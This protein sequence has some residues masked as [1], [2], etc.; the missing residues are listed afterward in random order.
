M[1]EERK[2]ER[3]CV[4]L[5]TIFFFKFGFLNFSVET[6]VSSWSSEVSICEYVCVG[7]RRERER[8]RERDESVCVSVCVCL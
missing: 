3:V 5:I 2:R 1:C 7:E 8:E 4:W 6:D